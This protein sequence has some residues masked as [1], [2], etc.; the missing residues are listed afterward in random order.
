MTIRNRSF[1]FVFC[2]VFTTLLPSVAMANPVESFKGTAKSAWAVLSPMLLPFSKTY[3][4]TLGIVLSVVCTTL[5][6]VGLMWA[7]KASREVSGRLGGVLQLFFYGLGIP[8]VLGAAIWLLLKVAGFALGMLGLWSGIIWVLMW[9]VRI[10]IGIGIVKYLWDNGKELIKSFIDLAKNT[11]VGPMSGTF[12]EYHVVFGAILLS[13]MINL[14]WAGSIFGCLLGLLGLYQRFTNVAQFVNSKLDAVKSR[15]TSKPREEDGAWRCPVKH[16]IPLIVDG[17]PVL[18]EEGYPETVEENCKG[19]GEPYNGWNPKEAPHCLKCHTANPYWTT[20]AACSFKGEDGKGFP[21]NEVCPQCFAPVGALEETAITAPVSTEAT[22]AT[23][24]CG[25][26]G[27]TNDQSEPFCGDCG[28]QLSAPTQT[29]L[30]VAIRPVDG[31]FGDHYK[32]TRL[33]D[34]H[35]WI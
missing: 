23:K 4:G 20:C 11:V 26:C 28:A 19:P 7:H 21:R 30:P 22:T 31:S 9:V 8:F 1:M 25:S 6:I 14:H 3:P 16:A 12:E 33:L 34:G 29:R 2:F 18:D 35:P 17:E 32:P 13:G 27:A 24:I 15:A 10:A 5:T